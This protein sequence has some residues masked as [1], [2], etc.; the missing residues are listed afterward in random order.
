[1]DTYSTI[2]IFRILPN[3]KLD[4]PVTG[5]LLLGSPNC[6]GGG[7]LFSVPPA[8]LPA[9][10]FQGELHLFESSFQSSEVPLKNGDH[11]TWNP[12]W[13]CGVKCFSTKNML[14]QNYTQ[15]RDFSMT[16]TSC[17]TTIL[18]ISSHHIRPYSDK[19]SSLML[20]SHGFSPIPQA[21]NQLPWD[22][23]FGEFIDS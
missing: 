20:C 22:Q 11:L 10:R 17:F 4:G 21:L 14:K 9:P 16:Q 15:K 7:R 13:T 8:T 18:E 19:H 3:K 6:F 12:G 23:I 5:M 1:M 2:C